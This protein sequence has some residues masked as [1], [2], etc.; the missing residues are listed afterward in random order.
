V[1]V[2]PE[3]CIGTAECVRLLPDAFRIDGARGVSE[4]TGAAPLAD[5]ARLAEAVRSCPTGAIALALD[6][7]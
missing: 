4:P 1:T 6:G 7:P 5:P 3:L 2:D